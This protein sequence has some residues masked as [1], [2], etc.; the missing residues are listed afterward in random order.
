[1]TINEGVIRRALQKADAVD[2][3]DILTAVEAYRTCA[4]AARKLAG[5]PALRSQC[6][7]VLECA[8]FC[9]KKLAAYAVSGRLAALQFPEAVLPGAHIVLSIEW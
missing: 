8:V 5:N 4:A 7:Q 3:D 2:R 1:M 9:E 6:Q